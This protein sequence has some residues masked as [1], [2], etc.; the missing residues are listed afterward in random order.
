VLIWAAVLDVLGVSQ[1]YA[2]IMVRLLGAV[3]F[4]AAS[5]LLDIRDATYRLIVIVVALCAAVVTLYTQ[6]VQD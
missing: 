1:I 3:V 5:R 4:K 6:A 2:E